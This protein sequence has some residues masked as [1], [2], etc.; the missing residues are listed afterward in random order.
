MAGGR[1]GEVHIKAI[2]SAM[3][4]SQLNLTGLDGHCL[5]SSPSLK[6]FRSVRS[7]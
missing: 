5:Q 4:I 1:L 6:V 3:Y 2:Y 7:S